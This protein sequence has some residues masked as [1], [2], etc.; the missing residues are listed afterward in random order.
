MSFQLQFGV[1]PGPG[2]GPPLL[3]W[4]RVILFQQDMNYATNKNYFVIAKKGLELWM[5]SGSIHAL[6]PLFMYFKQVFMPYWNA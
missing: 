3:P 5:N 1:Q 2:G 6:S 4:F